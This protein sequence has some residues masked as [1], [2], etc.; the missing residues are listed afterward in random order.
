MMNIL[1][2]ETGKLKIFLIII[3]F[4]FTLIY[5]ISSVFSVFS[6]VCYVN[7]DYMIDSEDE[8]IY[9]FRLNNSNFVVKNCK[10]ILKIQ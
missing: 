10:C 5:S 4:I 1:I 6:L 9:D 2:K 3:T 7:I 8:M